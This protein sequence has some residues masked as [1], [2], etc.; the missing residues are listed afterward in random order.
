MRGGVLRWVFERDIIVFH[1]KSE[2]A[3]LAPRDKKAAWETRKESLVVLVWNNRAV[4]KWGR[5]LKYVW[6]AQG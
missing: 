3:G 2:K 4:S 6:V 5:C 1:T